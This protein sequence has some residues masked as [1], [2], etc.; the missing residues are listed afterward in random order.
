MGANVKADIASSSKATCS[1]E[2]ASYLGSFAPT[3]VLLDRHRLQREVISLLY[4]QLAVTSRE[5]KARY[6]K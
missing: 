2:G 1:L 6:G 5:T 4:L 3:D